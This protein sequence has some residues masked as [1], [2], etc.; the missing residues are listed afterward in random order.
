MWLPKDERKL[1]RGYYWRIKVPEK[2]HWFKMSNWLP[3]LDS[4]RAK[5]P[6]NKVPAYGEKE[7]QQN[8]DI[9]QWEKEIPRLAALQKRLDIA[10]DVLQKRGLI[11]I[12]K[13]QHEPAVA[14]ITLTM[15][16]YDL[17]MKYRNWCVRSG[18][19]FAEYRRHWIWI[20]LGYVAGL[21]TKWLA[22]YVRN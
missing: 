4:W 2:D 11:E 9:T 7:D 18:Q 14:G 8:P 17:G 1:L 10:N 16:G 5:G 21:F 19:W 20:V 6:A 22:D 13:H 3:I 15:D 12:Q